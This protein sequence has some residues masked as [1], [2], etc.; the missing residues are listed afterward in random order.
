[1]LDVPAR[2]AVP[3]R[4]R[5]EHAV[6][7][8]PRELLE[9]GPGEARRP[10]VKPAG[11]CVDELAQDLRGY[12]VEAEQAKARGALVSPGP[13]AARPPVYPVGLIQAGV[14]G[15]CLGAGPAGIEGAGPLRRLITRAIGRIQRHAVEDD[16]DQQLEA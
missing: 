8:E 16:V 12:T 1:F 6:E 9:A 7:P 10:G 3:P 11:P 13:Q 5:G 4:R 15:L 14:S 2:T